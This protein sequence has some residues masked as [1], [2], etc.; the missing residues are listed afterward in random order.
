MDFVKCFFFIYWDDHLVF[1]F[2]LLLLMRCM[3]LINLLMLNHPCAA[4]MNPTWSWGMIFFMCCWFRLAKFLLRILCQYSS[5]IFAYNFLFL[6]VSLSGFG[7]RVIV[8]SQNVIGR[9]HPYSTFWKILRR[10]GINY[11][12]YVWDNL[13]VK[14][15]GP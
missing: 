13:P 11:F 4:G 1:D 2:L 10:L 5:K 14:P 7:I 15:C 6:V 12:L 8:A 9:I 3:M